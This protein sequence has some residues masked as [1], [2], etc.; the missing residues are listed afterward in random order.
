M[1]KNGVIQRKEIV[2]TSR[3]A[4]KKQRKENPSDI[5]IQSEDNKKRQN[6]NKIETKVQAY[7]YE[8]VRMYL[9]ACIEEIIGDESF[10]TGLDF[11]S[12]NLRK[13]RAQHLAHEA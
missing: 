1:N 2:F 13:K 10:R 6:S 8:R 3:L 12:F 5:E 4:G 9:S 11:L 7:I